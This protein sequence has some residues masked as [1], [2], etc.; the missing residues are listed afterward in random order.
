MK[1][2]T[3]NAFL[4]YVIFEVLMPLSSQGLAKQGIKK[5][6]YILYPI[7][8]VRHTTSTPRKIHAHIF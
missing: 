1:K 6:K 3:I 4:A 5:Y 7:M 8:H 2:A